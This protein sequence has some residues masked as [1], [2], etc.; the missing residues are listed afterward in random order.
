[1]CPS[2][3]S[4]NTNPGT[5]QA[6]RTS[7][8]VVTAPYYLQQLVSTNN[9]NVYGAID[10]TAPPITIGTMTAG[11][12]ICWYPVCHDSVV[13]NDLDGQL[14]TLPTWHIPGSYY[15]PSTAWQMIHEDN[16][17]LHR[18]AV[19]AILDTADHCRRPGRHRRITS[20][21]NIVSYTAGTAI[22]TDF[23]NAWWPIPGRRRRS[24]GQS[25]TYWQ[26]LQW[27][28]STAYTANTS[29]VSCDDAYYQCIQSHTSGAYAYTTP[30]TYE[31]T[32]PRPWD[33]IADNSWQWVQYTGTGSTNLKSYPLR[34]FGRA[35]PDLR[36][37]ESQ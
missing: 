31:P 27:Q 2:C 16:R 22:I 19:E 6:D 11:S 4:P 24:Y 15:L 25:N 17:P 3:N 23:T 12:I 10:V 21:G 20:V 33:V 37:L 30:P 29:Y 32:R 1:M 14:Y 26:S 34:V 5:L 9:P 7:W 18:R 13:Y 35:P 36:L 28:Y 8:G